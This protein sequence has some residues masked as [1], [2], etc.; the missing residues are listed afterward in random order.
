MAYVDFTH[1]QILQSI[2]ER[3]VSLGYVE[4]EMH[5]YYLLPDFRAS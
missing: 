4:H 3:Y 5:L 1:S 2:S